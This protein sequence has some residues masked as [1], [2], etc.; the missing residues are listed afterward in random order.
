MVL[1][2]GVPPLSTMSL[3][4]HILVPSVISMILISITFCL[5]PHEA[6]LDLAWQ[7]V[8]YGKIINSVTAIQGVILFYKIMKGNKEQTDDKLNELIDILV[9]IH[10]DEQV[11]KMEIERKNTEPK[12]IQLAKNMN[13]EHNERH[14]QSTA[15]K[16][17]GQ[18]KLHNNEIGINQQ[19]TR[20][21]ILLL[22][23]YIKTMS[24][25]GHGYINKIHIY[26]STLLTSQ[27]TDKTMNNK[28]TAT[29]INIPTS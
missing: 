16:V 19:K 18:R 7:K 25:I 13:T 5:R 26:F 11:N 29:N 9:K 6:M 27:H 4:T 22:R 24:L 17:I 10:N 3:F 20:Q 2:F 15:N 21:A 23:H 28:I 14:Q 1:P 8:V 12:V